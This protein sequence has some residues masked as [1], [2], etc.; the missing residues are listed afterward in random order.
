MHGS[1]AHCL[2]F[3]R[4]LPESRMTFDPDL[5]V[6]LEKKGEQNGKRRQTYI[7]D[8]SDKCCAAWAL[9]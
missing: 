6:Q 2:P 8:C 3:V 5:K 1:L 7:Y 4:R 9:D